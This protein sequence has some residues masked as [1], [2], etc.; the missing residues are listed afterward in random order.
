MTPDQD[1]IDLSACREPNPRLYT[2]E[3]MSAEDL[4]AIEHSVFQCSPG[5]IYQ[6]ELEYQ[7]AYTVGLIR[8][9]IT[10]EVSTLERYVYLVDLTRANR[11]TAEV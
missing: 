7:N 5:I 11:P 3:T 9:R 4:A 2:E 10:E 8:K 1:D 6:Y